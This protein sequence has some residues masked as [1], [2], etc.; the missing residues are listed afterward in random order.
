MVV[1][2]CVDDMVDKVLVMEGMVFGEYGI[3]IGKKYCLMKELGEGIINIMKML[4]WSLDLYN[5]LNFGKIFD[6]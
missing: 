4:K 3:G 1:W 5:L 2:C 6:M